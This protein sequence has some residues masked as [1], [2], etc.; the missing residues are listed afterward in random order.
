[1]RC[2]CWKCGGL[3]CSPYPDYEQ[4]KKRAIQLTGHGQKGALLP[5]VERRSQAE[6]QT[7]TSRSTLHGV[8]WLIHRTRHHEVRE[9]G[10]AHAVPR[11]ERVLTRRLL[12]ITACV[13]VSSC[14]SPT[15]PL[16]PPNQ[17]DTEGPDSAGNVTLS[18]QVIRGAN[19]YANNLN[20]GASSGQKADALTGKYRFKIR[21]AVGDQMEFFYIY[22]SVTSDRTY[23]TIG[24]AVAPSSSA[25]LF[26]TDAGIIYGPV[27]ASVDGPR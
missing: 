11:R 27:D 8:S 19:V 22:D 15:L 25:T 3:Q 9:P 21:A 17:P 24:I 16:P 10:I 1:M 5:L 14:L 6:V 26:P 12:L 18:G 23:F 13:A 4:G 20:S 7:R 2:P